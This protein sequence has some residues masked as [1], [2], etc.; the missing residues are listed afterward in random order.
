MFQFM[1]FAQSTRAKEFVAAGTLE[2]FLVDNVNVTPQS[3]TCEVDL[4]AFITNFNESK[5]HNIKSHLV[6]NNL[7]DR[8]VQ[9]QTVMS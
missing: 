9:K 2:A 6:G 4:P 5:W 8:E 1:G 7:I 3:S